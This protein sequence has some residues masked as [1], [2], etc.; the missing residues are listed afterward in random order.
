MTSNNRITIPELAVL[1]GISYKG[2]Q[3]HITAMKK[4]GMITRI[5]SR[6]AGSWKILDSTNHPKS[7]E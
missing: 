1:L 7:S 3:Y 5:G 6:K 4:E 2:V